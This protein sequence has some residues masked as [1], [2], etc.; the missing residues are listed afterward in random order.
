MITKEKN[1]GNIPLDKK[2]LNRYKTARAIFDDAKN[3]LSCNKKIRIYNTADI[4]NLDLNRLKILEAK[5][6]ANNIFNKYHDKNRFLN[7]GNEIIVSKSGIEESMEK[8]YNNRIKRD[9]IIEHL[10]IFAKLG[11]IIE[12]AI[13][14]NQIYER[15]NRRNILYWNYYFDNIYINDKK[16]IVEFEIRSIDIGLNQY[17]SQRLEIYN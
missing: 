7:N 8:I 17:R 6:L 10:I 2:L 11:M 15:K 13:L 12:R 1:K 9:F 4:E 14:V 3:I 16:Y 5:A